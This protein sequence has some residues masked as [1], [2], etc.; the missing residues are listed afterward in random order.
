MVVVR[1][2]LGSDAGAGAGRICGHD[3]GSSGYPFAALAKPENSTEKNEQKV[4]PRMSITARSR[5][6]ELS[7]CS[8]SL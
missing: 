1:K 3:A 4:V 5:L 6:K 2:K 8:G 7:L